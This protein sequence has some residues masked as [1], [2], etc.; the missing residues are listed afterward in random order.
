MLFIIG[1]DGSM[2]FWDVSTHQCL[3]TIQGLRE[4][5]WSIAHHKL[6]KNMIATG[7]SDS[8]LRILYSK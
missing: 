3:Q 5:I 8:C 2:K 7:G 1:H 4:T 6:Y